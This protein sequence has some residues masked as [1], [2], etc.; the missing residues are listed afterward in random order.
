MVSNKNAPIHTSGH[1]HREELKLMLNM[2][3]P[4]YLMP[5]HGD[6]MRIRLHAQLGEAS[7][8]ANVLRAKIGA[9][10]IRTSHGVGYALEVLP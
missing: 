3:R 5:V 9:D 2:T 8:R 4:K 1:G 10:R 6:H 7:A